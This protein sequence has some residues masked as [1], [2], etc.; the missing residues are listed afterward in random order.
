MAQ[1]VTKDAIGPVLGQMPPIL[2]S[3]SVTPG[4]A[5]SAAA[6]PDAASTRTEAAA[7]AG[8]IQLKARRICKFPFPWRLGRLN[9]RSD[10]HGLRPHDAVPCAPSRAGS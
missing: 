4:E 1:I 2:I 7:R 10:I 6:A 5:F 3:V 8:L 9:C